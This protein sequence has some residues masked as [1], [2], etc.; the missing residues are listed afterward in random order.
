MAA[1]HPEVLA[2][3]HRLADRLS[4]VAKVV[5]IL[6]TDDNGTLERTTENTLRD[7]ARNLQRRPQG[8]VWTGAPRPT[9]RAAGAIAEGT[10]S[11]S[12]R[13]VLKG[14]GIAGILV[15]TLWGKPLNTDETSPAWVNRHRPIETGP[16]PT[17]GARPH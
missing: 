3:G 6:T 7:A 12:G 8:P 13:V 10:A 17:M 9:T 4:E 1:A 11:V 5:K 15:E 14:V 16:V 2:A